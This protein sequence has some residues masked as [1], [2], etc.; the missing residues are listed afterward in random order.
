MQCENLRL[1]LAQVTPSTAFVPKT[2][3]ETGLFLLLKAAEL[4]REW[5]REIV[6]VQLDVKKAFDHVDHRA[7]FKAMKLQGVSFFSMALIAAIWKLYEGM[8]G[9]GDVK[10]SSDESRIASRSAGISSHLHDDHGIGAARFDKELDF[11]ETGLETGRLHAGCDVL[12]GRCGVDCCFGVRCR[13]NGVRSDRKTERGWT[14]GWRTENT[15]DE[16]P[17]DDGQ[18]H[19]GGRIGC[20]VGGSFGVCGIDGVSGR[21][22]KTC[23]RTQNSSSQQM[24]CKMETCV[25]F[26]MAPQI[27]AVEHHKNYDVAGFPLEL[28]CLDDGQGIERQN[29]ELECENGGECCWSEKAARNAAGTVVETMAKDWSSMDR[30][31]QYECVGGHQRSYAQLGWPRGKDGLLRNL[32]DG[33]EMSRNS[34]VEMETAQME[35]SG[36]RQMVWPTPTTVQNLQW[37][38]MV[39]GEVS[40][41]VGNADGL[42]K[43]VQDNTGWLHFAQNR[44]SW[45]Q[46]SK[47]GKSPEKMV[48]GASVTQVRPA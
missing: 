26:P 43:T 6:V 21:E 24:S 42:S 37:E 34:M 25:E 2:H 13:N 36:E 47:S 29:C 35:R 10:Q 12:C 31:M 18:K 33:S 45:K 14:D 39:A 32:C 11:T 27:V 40:K 41:F 46:F 1:R 8:L 3:A 4:S 5:Q 30:E 22:C 9:N 44:G 48:P 19:H 17:E 16:F 23:D 20:G 7:A 38:D 15:L 28:E